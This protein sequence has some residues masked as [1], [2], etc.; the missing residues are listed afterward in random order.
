MS[1]GCSRARSLCSTCVPTAAFVNPVFLLNN[2]PADGVR[3]AWGSRDI[4]AGE[5][6]V[7]REEDNVVVWVQREIT[8]PLRVR[9]TSGVIRPRSADDGATRMSERAELMQSTQAITVSV[10][11]A[12]QRRPM[13]QRG[14]G[15]H[16]AVSLRVAALCRSTPC[17]WHCPSLGWSS[18]ACS[19]GAG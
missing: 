16:R 11:T 4:D 5:L 14:F 8:Y 10:P 2:W 9:I 1:S 3:I 15:R 7:Q 18:S 6:A 17:S 12:A 19:T 13:R